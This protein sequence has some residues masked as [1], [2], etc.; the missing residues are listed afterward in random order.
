M[1]TH[2]ER[3]LNNELLALR[4]GLKVLGVAEADRK[5]ELLTE[6]RNSICK[7]TTLIAE[8]DAGPTTARQRLSISSVI[9]GKAFVG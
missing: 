8:S 2:I 7:I 6:L 9:S 1:N 5:Q 4:L 3:D